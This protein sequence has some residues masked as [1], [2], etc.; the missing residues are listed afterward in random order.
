MW[1]LSFVYSLLAFSPS[2][3]AF[4]PSLLFIT[5]SVLFSSFLSSFNSNVLSFFRSSNNHVFPSL[6]ALTLL[7]SQSRFGD[8]P[9]KLQVVC[10]QNGAAVLKGLTYYFLSCSNPTFFP[11]FFHVPCY[12]KNNFIHFLSSFLPPYVLSFS[13]AEHGTPGVSPTPRSWKS[14]TATGTCT[15]PDSR[16]GGP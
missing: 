3:P 12:Q 7:D 11:S 9:I 6:E 13:A 8:K 16:R 15:T 5:Y 1:F 10:P 2:I 14:K 4:L